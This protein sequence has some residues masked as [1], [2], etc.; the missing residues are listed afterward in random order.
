M[1]RGF[2][3]TLAIVTGLLPLLATLTAAPAAGASFPAVR[4]HGGAVVSPESDSTRVGLEI[5]RRGGNAA[6]AAVA[7]ALAMAVVHPE[8][9]NLGGGGFAVVK[10]GDELASLDF[11]EV[12]PA[13]A[14][15]D[16]YLDD[17]REPV[18]DASRVGPLAAGVPGSPTGLYELHRRFG[19][20]PWSEVVTPAARLAGNGFR[21]SRRLHEAVE[22]DL[23]LLARFPE[24]AAV[25]LPDGAPPA[26]GS[27]MRIPA[28]AAT[29]AAYGDR[30]PDAIVT[31]PIAV[32]IEV[33][34]DRHGGILTAADLAA[35]RPAWREPVRGSVRGWELAGMD[36]PSSGGYLVTAGLTLF[37]ALG[38]AELPRGGAE[39]AHLAAEVWRRLFAARALL[40]DPST[41]EAAVSDLLAGEWLDELAASIDRG[42][43]TPS[44]TIEP[45]PPGEAGAEAAET[46]HLAVIDGE[47]NVV[48]L[49][50]TLNG[51]FGCGLLVPEAGFLLNNEMDDFAAAPGR[52][53]MF[54]LIQGP[55]NEVRPGKR[56]LSSMS[57]TIAWKDGEVVAVGGRGGS[58]I[59][60]AVTQVLLN[61][62]FDEDGLQAA[63]DRPRLHHQWLPDQISYELDALA[64]ETRRALVSRGHTLKGPRTSAKVHA[65]RLLA[66]G[67]FEAA[68]DPR[69]PAVGGI[70]DPEP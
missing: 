56:M 52:P 59:P 42:Q 64:P 16:M 11:R 45:T 6:D 32:A 53:N 70:V 31:G 46:N 10:F 2:L 38:W 40:G 17:D 51:G 41:S 33:A 39:R 65:T 50:T 27:V 14:T 22:E 4:G 7:T 68:G 19:R 13:A 15:R 61:L 63:I 9:G 54:G 35:Y 18:E 26:I 69:G 20:L 66:D 62:L 29:L 37:D 1:S 48:S 21:V 58:R 60:T 43:A 5:L 49:T 67:R 12:A 44:D 3:R 36:L 28:L 47:G 23:E 30:G 55:A 24:T 8:A 25:W 57:P 34:S